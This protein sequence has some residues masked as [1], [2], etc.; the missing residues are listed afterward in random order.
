MCISVH[1]ADLDAVEMKIR[2]N[3]WP[4]DAVMGPCRFSSE[5]GAPRPTA[6]A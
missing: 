3:Q 2:H 1:S 4:S 5:V 6:V